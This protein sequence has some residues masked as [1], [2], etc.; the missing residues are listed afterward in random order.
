M[1]HDGSVTHWLNRLASEDDSVAEREL[2]DRYFG[3]LVEFARQKLRAASRAV[4]DEEDLAISAMNSFF[5]RA[6]G[7]Q[8][9]KLSSRRDLW[10]ILMTIVARK[11]VNRLK[12]DQALKRGGPRIGRGSFGHDG[13]GRCSVVME[14]MDSEPA[15]EMLAELNEELHRRL[16]RLDGEQLREVALLRLQGFTNPEIAERLGVAERTV[17]RKV[18]RIRREWTEA[19]D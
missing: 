4:E 1:S 9:P 7:G 13:D 5:R 10:T 15:P 19:L 18:Y 14:L 8:F 16:T 2:F 17:R 3:K 12:K 6:A 11:T